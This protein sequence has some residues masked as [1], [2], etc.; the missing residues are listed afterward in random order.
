MRQHEAAT[1]PATQMKQK[2][3]AEKFTSRQ[4]E[5]SRLDGG[6]EID[7]T[8]RGTLEPTPDEPLGHIVAEQHRADLEN[9]PV[10]NAY[11]EVPLT[12]CHNSILPLYRQPH[13]AFQEFPILDEFGCHQ[14]LPDDSAGLQSLPI[15]LP[16]QVAENGEVTTAVSADGQSVSAQ[17][18]RQD[19]ERFALSFARD[20][21]ALHGHNHDHNCSFTCI[22]YVKAA[23]KNVAEA[24]LNTIT[25]IVCRFFFYVTLVFM[26]LED[27]VERVRRVRRRGKARVMEPYV[28]N[29][30]EHNELGRVQVERQTPFRGAT[31]DVGQCGPRCNV[32]CQF[33]P[34]AAVLAAED[35]S[36]DEQHDAA[37]TPLAAQSPDAERADAENTTARKLA[38]RAKKT[39][40]YDK[41][42]A[43]YGI[44]LQL[45]CNAAMRQAARSMLAMWQAA[46]NTD[47]YITKYGTKA[48]EQLQNLI[49]QFALGLRRLELEEEQERPADEAVSPNPQAYKQPAISQQEV[50]VA[51]F[52]AIAK[53]R[54]TRRAR[55]L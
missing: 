53:R 27:G 36:L 44:R 19:A 35:S 31:T 32:D 7:G 46:H 43:F 41:A 8:Q 14:D 13:L 23:V 38:V 18:Y 55:C 42:E 52:A 50:H 47:Y 6:L 24:G 11:R 30:H 17:E 2:V 25:N 54:V 39:L 4:Q 37:A 33:M 49:A 22:K 48:L 26:V 40:T 16:W 10:R 9:R 5:L 51:R 1:L 21:R 45:P 12:G 20:T 29:T 15:S 3:P 34:R 28:A